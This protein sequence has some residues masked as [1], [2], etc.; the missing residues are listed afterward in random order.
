M[1]DSIRYTPT[2]WADGA[3]GGTPI[4]AAR[5]NNIEQGVAAATKQVNANTKDIKT[6]GD[7]VSQDTAA[8]YSNLALGAAMSSGNVHCERLGR[9]VLLHVNAV[10][11]SASHA[12]G[13][14]HGIVIATGAPKPQD[15]SSAFM[16]NSSSDSIRVTVGGNGALTLHWSPATGGREYNGLITYVAS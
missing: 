16:L 11:F 4:T 5:L 3:D 7:S 14:N 1:A 13:L 6:L 2:T 15:G 9:L 12:D 10:K 8:S